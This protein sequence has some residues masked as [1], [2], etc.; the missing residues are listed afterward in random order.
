MICEANKLLG[1]IFGD[2]EVVS[3]VPPKGKWGKQRCLCRCSCGKEKVI[4]PNFLVKGIR[5]SCG[6]LKYKTGSRSLSWK[7]YGEISSGFFDKIRSH[8]KERGILFKVTIKEIWELFLKQK[9]KCSLT[10]LILT[11]QSNTMVW[12]GNGFIG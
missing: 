7:G 4:K 5:K 9:R 6:C 8:A 2:L 12:D 11:F 3:V 10:G 1:K